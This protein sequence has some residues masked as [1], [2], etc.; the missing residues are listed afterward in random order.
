MTL[1]RTLGMAFASASLIALAPVAAQAQSQGMTNA[2]TDA[3]LLAFTVNEEVRAKPD[4][5]TLGAGVTSTAPTA[6]EALRANSAAMERLIKA[7]K[8]R[9]IK[10]QDIQTTGV[11]LSPVYDYS[12]QQQGLPP[13]MTGYQVTNMVRAQTGDIKGLGELLDAMVAA[14]G[15]NIDGPYFSVKDAD[16]M[17]VG[18]RKAAMDKAAAKAADYAKLAG[19]RSARLIGLSEGGGFPQAPAP[20]MAMDRMVLTAG[21]AEAAP[22]EPGQV[23]NTLTLSFQ[24]RLER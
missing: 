3:P 23:G 13:K 19:Y 7:V 17:L 20:V 12:G 8:A 9:G 4:R 11:S 6:T 15:T 1:F 5:A 14:G 2:T 10:D 16:T 24:Y 18:A 22:I 21:K